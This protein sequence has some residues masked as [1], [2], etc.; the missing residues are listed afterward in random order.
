MK[1]TKFNL[2]NSKNMNNLLYIDLF[3]GAG[4][5]S[6]GVFESGSA[7][8]VACVNH[9]A[10]AIKSHAANHPEVL[11]YTED[12]K[13]LDTAPMVLKLNEERFRNPEAKVVLWASCECTN[14][15]KAKG[16]KTRDPDSRSLAE[17]LYRYIK[18]IDPDYIQ[19]ENVVEFLDWGPLVTQDGKTIPDKNHKGESFKKWFSHVESMGFRGE[20]RIFNAADFGSYTSRK[21]LFVQFARTGLSLAWPN[22]TN[23]RENWK[24]CR[25]VLDLDD[26]GQSIFTRKKPLCDATL[27]RITEGVRKFAQPQ[28]IM[29]YM[30]GSGHVHSIKKPGPTVCTQKNLYLAT[31]KFMTRYFSGKGHN[32]SVDAP[33]GTLTTIP[34]QYPVTVTFMDNYFG[35]GYPTS[36]EKPCGTLCTKQQRFPVTAVFL[37]NY[38]SGGGQISGTHNPC[39]TLRTVPKPRIVQCQFLDQQYGKS[40][41][42]SL[43]RPFPAV[44]TNPHYGVVTASFIRASMRPNTKGL[45]SSVDFP[46][47]TLLTRD[48]FY[49]DTCKLNT[50]PVHNRPQEEDS[51]VML[52]LKKIMREKGIADI[53]MRPI[54]IKESL[55]VMGFPEDYKLCG[56]QT[57]QRKFIG[58]AVEVNMAKHLVLA[59]AKSI[60]RK[61]EAA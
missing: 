13:T 21:R 32:T 54:S 51:E 40:K 25:E 28:F 39:P 23:N 20:W 17:H 5:T 53:C 56:T 4:G 8:V 58:N 11:H 29:R 42:A 3:C 7:K 38:Y 16:G 49:L 31:S 1:S 55:R 27:K 15:S 6:T 19:V 57:A 14:F 9:D 33:C 43:W 50:W 35:R 46:M 10:D 12:I 24:P 60:K 52:D 47:K 18:A 30:S 45:V 61:E 37:A 22:P 2:L 36:I 59:L 26:F 48:Y 44:M 34:H 41:S